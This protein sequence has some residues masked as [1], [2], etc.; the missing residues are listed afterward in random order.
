MKNAVLII[1]ITTL[2]FTAC[3]RDDEDPPATG[4]KEQLMAGRWLLVGSAIKTN[5]NGAE[6]TQDIYATL[7]P[8]EKDNINI[9][10]ADSHLIVDEG[11]IKCD[12]GQQQDKGTWAMSEDRTKLIITP[13][14][15][16]VVTQTI[17]Q[18]DNTTLKLSV[19]QTESANGVTVT[20]TFSET[21][22]HQN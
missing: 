5:I 3:S 22:T 20:Y 21:F 15:G 11:A 2:C 19:A 9:Y 8:C 14:S 17:D 4:N 13:V 10:K 12:T 6:T 1:L 7:R 18:F 16:S